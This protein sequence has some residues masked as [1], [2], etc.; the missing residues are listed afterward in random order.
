MLS[1]AQSVP[2]IKGSQI[3]YNGTGWR[4]DFQPYAPTA[5]T[6]RKYTWYSFL[7]EAETNPES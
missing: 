5:F 1:V 7:L 2:G 4:S 3:S 6:S